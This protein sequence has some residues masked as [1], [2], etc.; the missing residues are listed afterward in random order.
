MQVRRGLQVKVAFH[1]DQL[2]FS[3]PGGIGTYV[4]ELLKALPASDGTVELTPFYSKWRRRSLSEAPF[5]TDGRY[6]GVELPWSIRA[7]YPAWD[8]LGRPRLPSSLADHDIVHA[9]N[10]AAVPAVRRGQRLV[11]TVHDLAFERYPDLFPRRWLSL[12]RRGLRAAIERADAIIVPSESVRDDL[13]GRA[14]LDLERIRVTPL[15]ASRRD[16]SA[17]MIQ[18]DR[19]GLAEFGITPPY[20]LAVGTI[21]PRKN[22]VRLV[23]A[24]RRLATQGLPQSLVLI[25][26]DGWGAEELRAELEKGGPGRVVRAGGFSTSMLTTAYADADVV[27]YVSLYEGFGLP[28]LEA[29]S[30]GA[31]VVTSNT[32]SLPEVAG[33]AALLVDPEDVGEI[34]DALARVLTDP[35]L[36]EDLRRRGRERAAVFSW[37][38]TASATL[39]VY[40]HVTGAS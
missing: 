15:G 2:W 1:V 17:E 10:H 32:S 9:T 14:D 27:A 13:I 33:D 40:R 38:A 26:D 8:W 20:V 37:A 4:S 5:T 25:G 7:L 29:M 39:D 19:E 18:T 21:E 28:V 12:Y 35:A 3:A 31:P 6:P 16:R 30:A 36:A 34:S 11:V 23:D 24:Y 22:L